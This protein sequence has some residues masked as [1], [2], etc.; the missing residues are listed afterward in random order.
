[1]KNTVWKLI[2]NNL[3]LKILAVILALILWLLARSDVSG[4]LIS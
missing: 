2:V 3:G 4:R 1:M